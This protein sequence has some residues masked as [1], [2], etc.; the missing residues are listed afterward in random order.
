LSISTAVSDVHT[1]IESEWPSLESTVPLAY[2]NALL[3]PP[4]TTAEYL[5]VEVSWAGGAPATIGAPGNNR[6]R[7]DGWIWLHAFVR[8]GKG[9]V[10]A[11]EI[12]AKAATIFEEKDFGAAGLVCSAME[13]G[14]GQSGSTDGLWYGQSVAIPFFFDELV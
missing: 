13:P 4:S 8:A 1:K 3:Q 14:A 2:P 10:R 12:A 6:A 11:F 7:R 9:D 5:V